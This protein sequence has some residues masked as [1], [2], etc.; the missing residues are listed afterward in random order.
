MKHEAQYKYKRA[1]PTKW[2][3]HCSCGW[4]TYGSRDECETRFSGHDLEWV[5]EDRMPEWKRRL[6]EIRGR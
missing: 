5:K 4:F 2:R 1:E 6:S 3:V